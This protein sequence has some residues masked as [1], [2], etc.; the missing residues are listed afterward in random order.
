MVPKSE[1]ILL[2]ADLAIDHGRRTSTEVARL[3]LRRLI[4]FYV[5]RLLDH[6]AAI[7]S[8]RRDTEQPLC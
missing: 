7:R 2:V 8:P 5:T 3:P 6:T 4:Y 1:G